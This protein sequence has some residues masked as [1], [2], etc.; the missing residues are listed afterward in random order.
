MQQVATS[1]QNDPNSRRSQATKASNN[2]RRK[3]VSRNFGYLFVDTDKRTSKDHQAM[4]LL[5]YLSNKLNPTHWPPKEYNQY[6]LDARAFLLIAPRITSEGELNQV[7]AECRTENG[8]PR[9]RIFL[10][11][12]EKRNWR[13]RKDF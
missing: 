1:G 12:G 10:Q 3:A 2:G 9:V 11:T 6:L 5:A 7:I 4:V 13:T 8:P